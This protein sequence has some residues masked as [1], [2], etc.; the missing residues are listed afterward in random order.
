MA[1]VGA[2]IVSMVMSIVS[3]CPGEVVLLGEWQH[4]CGSSV[5]W[6]IEFIR[7]L[8]GAGHSVLVMVEANQEAVS[9]SQERLAALNESRF[10]LEYFP[11]IYRSQEFYDLLA[12]SRA[13]SQ[14][15]LRGYDFRCGSISAAQRLG[16][17][18]VAEGAHFKGVDLI[19]LALAALSPWDAERMRLV[20]EV[21]TSDLIEL[22]SF[23]PASSELADNVRYSSCLSG[24]TLDL[25]RPVLP[26]AGAVDAFNFRDRLC[27]ENIRDG[28]I[29]SRVASGD[30]YREPQ[31]VVVW[32]ASIHAA[33]SLES[34]FVP[35]FLG[36]MRSIGYWLHGM[37]VEITSV[38][39]SVRGGSYL[40]TFT[41]GE[42]KVPRIQ[43]A[44]ESDSRSGWINCSDGG[45][46]PSL[47]LGFPSTASWAEVFDEIYLCSIGR[48]VNLLRPNGA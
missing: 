36:E 26:G 16:M 14:L 7:Q 2:L 13:D 46:C 17:R 39:V 9:L 1:Y 37:G 20:R 35:K 47:L 12:L 28:V 41:L 45:R 31:T 8:L 29:E 24:A 30:K 23:G 19:E 43:G 6:K 42:V 44:L 27:A 18:A 25:D 4:G 5:R 11:H 40:D 34:V 10:D 48:P 3:I 38:G 33:K 32:C 22:S 21:G 15:E